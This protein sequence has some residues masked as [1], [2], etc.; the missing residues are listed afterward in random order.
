LAPIPFL[1]L[2]RTARPWWGAGLGFVFGLAYFGL[3]LYWILLFGELG[4]TAL[5]VLSAA[6]TAA[7]GALAPVLWR[8]AH[9]LLST[10]GL[11]ALWTV[12]EF[13]RGA[14][15]LGGFGWGQ[16]GSTQTANPFLLPLASVTGVWGISL[17]VMLV[18]GLLLLA[19][20][21]G[22][23]RVRSASILVVAGV[24]LVVAPAAIPAPEANGPAIDVAALQVDVRRAEDLPREAEDVAVATMNVDLHRELEADPPDL[25]V[26][27]E[28]SLDPG[29]V[30]D[31][32]T[33]Q[34]VRDAVADVGAPTL[35]GAVLDDPD[36]TQHTS[37]L[38]F[39][40]TGDLVDRYDKVR[41]VPFGEYVPFRERLQWI[42]AIDQIPVDRT[43]GESI[44][45]VAVDGLPPFGTPICYENSFPSIERAMVRDGAAFFVLTTNNASYGETAAS[46][47]HLVMSRLRAVE[48]GRWVVHAAVSGISAIVAPD[49][50]IVA[51]NEL[52]VPAITRHQIRASTTNTLY[53]RL[54]DWV[55]WACLA[56]CAGL[57]LMPR[58]RSARS[59]PPEALVRPRTLVIL[60]TYDEAATIGSV[61]DG[62]LGLEPPVDIL[63]VDD[64]SPDGTAAIVRTRA[65]ADPRVRL[66]ERDHKSGLASAYLAGFTIALEG[67]YDLVVEMDADLSHLPEE[68]PR[69][70]AAANERDLVI[71]SRYV[72]GGAVTNWSRSRIALSRAGN[73]YARLCLGLPLHDATS[74]FRVYRRSLLGS[75]LQDPIRSDGYGFQI[76]LADRAWRSGHDVAE[77]PITFR[78]RQQGKSK[79]SRRIV[80]EALWLVTVWGLRERFRPS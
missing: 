50:G 46:R 13:F 28:G 36:G 37:V 29:A 60:P 53:V 71:G 74:G 10:V 73:L 9:P 4:W 23:G 51:R 79:I 68:L 47:Q 59:A 31:G 70:L 57:F 33:V 65:S 39:D 11:A 22:R 32:A 19:L 7:F 54:G 34:A 69:L 8:P 2:V 15:P 1:W 27:G 41:L 25:A 30:G 67:E 14:W 56:L 72:P 75:L 48:T 38:L 26:W 18:S 61:L 77:V 42:D 35:A 78:E 24:V 52:F 58:R 21:R 6:F 44:H 80:A 20:E 3:V 12:L 40:G 76:E 64:G 63:V 43:P 45:T 55:V 5:V 66:L 62:L 49:G 17:I 16:S